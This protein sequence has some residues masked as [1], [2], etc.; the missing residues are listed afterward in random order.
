MGSKVV[1]IVPE[2]DGINP[3]PLFDPKEIQVIFTWSKAR[4][5]KGHQTVTSCILRR[6]LEVLGFGT[7]IENP[8]DE[9]NID[10]GMRWAF[11][12]A[13]Q[14]FIRSFEYRNKVTVSPSFKK[15]MDEKFRRA[16]WEAQNEG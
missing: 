15:L 5:G 1:T 8:L 7:A 4:L 2:L 14:S 11:K 16:L 10:E 3:I 9:S 12:R 6:E 13:I